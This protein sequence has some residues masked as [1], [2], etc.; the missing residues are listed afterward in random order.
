MVLCI[1]WRWTS[2]A[3]RAV[4]ATRQVPSMALA[5]ATHNARTTSSSLMARPTSTGGSQTQRTRATTWGLVDTGPVVP[6]WTS[7]RPTAWR[8][9]THRI[10]ATWTRSFGAKA[11]PVVIMTRGN[12]TKESATK[13]A[14]TSTLS[15]WAIR[16]STAEVPPL[17]LTRPNP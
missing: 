13:T 14:V 4:A 15:A 10:P 9:L 5:T 6:R 7:G 11:L 1:L 17:L 2:L 12:D 16:H 3:G 8:L